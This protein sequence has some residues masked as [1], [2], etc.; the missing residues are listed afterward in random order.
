MAIRRMMSSAP[1]RR[2]GVVSS[3]D[4]D[5]PAARFATALA[6]S[7]EC[8]HEIARIASTMPAPAD[9]HPCV[10]M[11]SPRPRAAIAGELNQCDVAIINH[12]VDD[13]GLLNRDRTKAS[14]YRLL[15]VIEM[16]RVPTIVVL[17][18]V[19]AEPTVDQ[20]RTIARA[21]R[22]AEVIAV[23]AAP[24]A[25]RLAS[26][27]GVD[28]STLWLLRSGPRT[29]PGT[30]TRPRRATIVFWGIIAPGRGIE[31]MIDAMQ[32][33]S[34]LDVRCL[35]AGPTSDGQ[36]VSEAG[37]YRETLI[38]RSWI[39]GVAAHVTF[40]RDDADYTAITEALREA[41]AVV[42]PLDRPDEQIDGFVEEMIAAGVP[43]IATDVAVSSQI[44]P[45]TAAL[46][47]P[48][49]NPAALTDAVL[50]LLIDP[51]LGESMV[52]AT[53]RLFPPTTWSGVAQQLDRLA[54]AAI[55]ATVTARR[56][57]V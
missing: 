29:R 33:L 51:H 26:T 50:R 42:V 5:A 21:C 19:P 37:N 8:R 22:S 6:Q 39:R 40:V 12:S 7:L 44:L 53:A 32:H 15:D 49:R 11:A 27:Y 13:E 57:A 16:V 47:V 48:P 25:V 56:P 1:R 38:R 17:H 34:A 35:I 20:R 36:T 28:P 2:Y 41:L 46:L 4:S 24:A 55:R 3:W 10:S 9:A 52:G 30:A 54:D 18:H 43:I 14:S 45:A 31:S 23:T